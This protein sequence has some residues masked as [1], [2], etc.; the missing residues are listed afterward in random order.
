ME[1]HSVSG[2]KQGRGKRDPYRVGQAVGDV[3]IR[4]LEKD[5]AGSAMVSPKKA[6]NTSPGQEVQ[7]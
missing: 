4:A 6:P 2:K 3:A 7:A 1:Q 5:Q